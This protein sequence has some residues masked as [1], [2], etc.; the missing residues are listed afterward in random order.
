MIETE[1]HSEGERQRKRD[2]KLVYVVKVEDRTRR[3]H[4]YR[5]PSP[6]TCAVGTG[7]DEKKTRVFV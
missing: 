2:M 5:I 4:A 7:D 1:G 3:T 6:G